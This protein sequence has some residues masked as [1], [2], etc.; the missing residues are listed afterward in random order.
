MAEL[1]RTNNRILVRTAKNDKLNKF[2]KTLPKW[3]YDWDRREW[4]FPATQLD[5]L[6]NQLDEEDIPINLVDTR[7]PSVLEIDGSQI[8][9]KLA[10]HLADW[11]TVRALSGFSYIKDD[12]AIVCDACE[13]AQVTKMLNEQDVLFS[14]NKL[15]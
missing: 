4:S 13:L 7:V 9:L 2:F 3:F 5:A 8:K 15:D 6:I 11:E 10:Y 14:V 12:R 1:I